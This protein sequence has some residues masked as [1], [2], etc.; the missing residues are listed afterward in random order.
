[1]KEAGSPA[2]SALHQ[3]PAPPR[4]FTGR[5]EEI[6]ELLREMENGVS[7]SG[8]HGM[9]GVGKTA[10][11]L[12]LADILKDRYPDAQFYL[13]LKGVSERALSPADAMAHI[14]RAYHPEAKLPDQEAELSAI[15]NSVL[16]GKSAL[17]LMDNAKDSAT[18]RRPES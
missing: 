3:L 12:K 11:A 6:D 16:H 5:R 15:Y 9:G 18:D 17:L 13:D 2:L 4:D 1:M 7:I 14:C 10:L 8:L